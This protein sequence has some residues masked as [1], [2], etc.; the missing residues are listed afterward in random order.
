MTTSPHSA[1]RNVGFDLLRTL[2]C[3]MV[4]LLHASSQLW[5]MTAVTDSR[6]VAM[7]IWNTATRGAVP[8]FFMISGALFLGGGYP[9]RKLWRKNIPHLVVVYIIW[10]LFYGVDNMTIPGF[11]ENPMGVIGQALA[12]RY[13]LW[14][15]PAMIG[16]YLVLPALYGAVHY[17]NGRALKPL[18]WVFGLF[19]I[20]SGT[21]IGLEGILPGELV[22]AARKITPEL[23]S[24]CGYFILG[25]ALS[26]IDPARL[27][28]WPLLVGFFGTVAITAL[29]GVLYSRHVGVATALM[30]DRFTVSSC[31]MA[32]CLFL[33]FRTVKLSAD[34]RTARVMRR[35]SGCTLGVYLL[36]PFVLDVLYKFGF[37]TEIAHAAVAVPVVAVVVAAISLGIVALLRLIPGAGKW[38][39]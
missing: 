10:S 35:L 11:L 29:A 12:G 25:Y 37:H 20:L 21:I 8:V 9:G 17:D 5:Y 14:F 16:I 24:Y 22:L 28:R 2:A 38:V 31:A 18:L 7:H 13:H 30:H 3:F 4:V 34:T 23:C 36:H 1:R 15:L 19:G 33:L 39:V 26:R 32:V 6:W 27:R